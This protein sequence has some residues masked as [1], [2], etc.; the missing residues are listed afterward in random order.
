MAEGQEP[1]TPPPDK[2]RRAVIFATLGIVTILGLAFFIAAVVGPHWQ[3]HKVICHVWWPYISEAGPEAIQR[4]GGPDRALDRL[5]AYRRLPDWMKPRRAKANILLGYCGPRAIPALLDAFAEDDAGMHYSAKHALMGLAGTRESVHALVV[6]L[7]DENPRVRE[8]AAIVLGRMGRIA[9][10]AVFAL[11][12]LLKDED[13]DVREA[14]RKALEAIPPVWN[15]H[16]L[17]PEPHD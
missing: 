5:V 10:E 6:A 4:L 12:Q 15:I 13:D 11:K 14:A 2:S 1:Y 17:P 7:R 8:G 16:E 3:T 9:E